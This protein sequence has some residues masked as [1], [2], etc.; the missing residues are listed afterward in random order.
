[1]YHLSVLRLHF[2]LSDMDELIS[3]CY[4]II[5][6][7]VPALFVR[8][9]CQQTGHPGIAP[10]AVPGGTG[11]HSGAPAKR[12]CVP[13]GEAV[14][15]FLKKESGT[16]KTVPPFRLKTRTMKT[17]TKRDCPFSSQKK[18]G[19]KKTVPPFRKRKVE[20]K[21][22]SPRFRNEKGRPPVPSRAE[23]RAS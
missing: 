6:E 18:S 1:M 10:T 17:R 4:P 7:S 22:P 12:P 19:T 20:R 16:K 2:L 14:P 21:R 3:M 5:W 13:H 23:R 8:L 11:V 15:F 9:S